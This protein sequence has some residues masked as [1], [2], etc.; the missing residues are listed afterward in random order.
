MCLTKPLNY[1]QDPKSQELKTIKD[2]S[3]LAPSPATPAKHFKKVLVLNLSRK[4][5]HQEIK[6][7]DLEENQSQ[8]VKQ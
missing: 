2:F 8:E 4:L 1:R 5:I 6:D 3:L 7:N